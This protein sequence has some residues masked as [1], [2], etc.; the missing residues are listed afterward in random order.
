MYDDKLL[1]WV[2]FF[3]YMTN[4]Y[5]IIV[6]ILLYI[7]RN[8]LAYFI[9][10]FSIFTIDKLI[11]LLFMAGSR[12][13]MIFWISDIFQVGFIY[14][15]VVEDFF[16]DVNRSLGLKIPSRLVPQVFLEFI[17]FFCLGILDNDD[18]LSYVQ[19]LALINFLLFL[20][21]FF[22]YSS[23]LSITEIN[24]DI[25]PLLVIKLVFKYFYFTATFYI[26]LCTLTFYQDCFGINLGY[27]Q[28]LISIFSI[29]F[30]LI[31]RYPKLFCK[32]S[33]ELDKLTFFIVMSQFLNKYRISKQIFKTDKKSKIQNF[34][35]IQGCVSQIFRIILILSFNREY[36]FSEQFL[37]ANSLKNIFT[38]ATFIL[39]L[40]YFIFEFKSI[41][42]SLFKFRCFN[43]YKED[44]IKKLSLKLQRKSYN[45][46][47]IQ[48]Y[49][50]N[51]QNPDDQLINPLL[52]NRDA[53]KEQIFNLIQIQNKY[54]KQKKK[55]LFKNEY[56]YFQ[57]FYEYFVI[58][59]PE[60]LYLNQIDDIFNIFKRQNQLESIYFQRIFNGLAFTETS[61]YIRN[62]INKQNLYQRDKDV[63]N[64]IS[65]ICFTK[66]ISSH[67]M[68]SNAQ[69]LYDLYQHY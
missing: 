4:I 35:N 65:I 40:I 1:F 8:E 62:L 27:Y 53:L 20:T 33:S 2:S 55:L 26:T 19:L 10:F 56:L 52:Q 68:F 66:H 50:E 67:M 44:Q 64:L 38:Y 29:I 22:T 14:I 32:D 49:K 45:I 5:S 25:Q 21:L 58:N 9:V 42:H 36:I 63:Q 17:F 39:S 41:Y 24:D 46:V 31:N 11:T 18:G 37:Q 48:F 51:P 28:F 15:F 30:F 61:S 6:A 16:E 47:I 12:R 3:Y 60:L 23:I 69:I 7:Q 54:K 57:E 59:S 13:K 34:Q 43:I